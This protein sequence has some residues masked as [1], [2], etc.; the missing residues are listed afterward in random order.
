MYVFTQALQPG[1]LVINGYFTLYE[2][3]ELE[4]YKGANLV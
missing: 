3:P 1:I 4:K 2:V